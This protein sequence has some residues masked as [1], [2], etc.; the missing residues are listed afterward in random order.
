MAHYR[1]Q[2]VHSARTENTAETSLAPLS[3]EIIDFS[4][5]VVSILDKKQ[6]A[7]FQLALES[8]AEKIRNQMEEWGKDERC[9]P[10]LLGER[11]ASEYRVLEDADEGP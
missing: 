9:S 6:P 3:A 10:K 5:E 4:L 7:N 8:Y 2:T 1:N 11:D